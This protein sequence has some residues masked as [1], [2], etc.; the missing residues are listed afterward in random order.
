MLRGYPLGKWP[1]GGSGSEPF[2]KLGGESGL[3]CSQ[4]TSLLFS[5]VAGW[6]SNA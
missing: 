5:V 3:S 4:D 1:K 6:I 2:G